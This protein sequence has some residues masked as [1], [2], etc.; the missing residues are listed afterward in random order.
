MDMMPAKDEVKYQIELICRKTQWWLTTST[1]ITRNE[2][3]EVRKMLGLLEY[4]VTPRSGWTPNETLSINEPICSEPGCKAGWRAGL[5]N[6]AG[7]GY[8]PVWYCLEHTKSMQHTPT[9]P[10]L[11]PDRN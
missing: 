6:Y 10:G 11:S 5:I 4:L 3:E 9:P 7:A 8:D 2:I 1:P